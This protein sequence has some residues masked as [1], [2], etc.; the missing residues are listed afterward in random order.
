[1]TAGAPILVV[2]DDPAI[3]ESVA[4]AVRSVG[5]V[6]ETAADGRTALERLGRHRYSLLVLDVMLPRVNG[7][8]VCRRL[9]AEHDRTPILMLTA[10]DGISDRV[11]GLEVGADDYL[12]KPFALEELLA[13]IR[14]LVRREVGGAL[15]EVV[16]RAGVR[17]ERRSRQVVRDGRPVALTATEFA[18]LDELM[19][20]ADRVVSAARLYERVWGYDA[21]A[22]S[23]A[24]HVF[25]GGLRRKLEAGGE[26][27][28]VHNVRGVGFRFRAP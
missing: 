11:R 23:N 7:L 8:E 17:L 25:V 6:V 13:R 9:R 20:H 15:T 1:M 21:S 5:H 26:P 12:V 16:E 27:R 19:I 14:A 3:R 4:L 24:L 28:V 2:E 22:R 18:L 10:R